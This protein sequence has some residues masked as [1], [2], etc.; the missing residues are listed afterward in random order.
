MR[1]SSQW[2]E[3]H[4]QPQEYWRDSA[5]LEVVYVVVDLCLPCGVNI[6]ERKG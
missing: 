4:P 5:E 6:L 3:S 2:K 1:V